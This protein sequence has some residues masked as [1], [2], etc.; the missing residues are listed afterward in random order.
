MT[1]REGIDH[2]EAGNEAALRAQFDLLARFAA[3]VR[4][5]GDED[6]IYAL[7][8]EV[9][10]E[11][12]GKRAIISVS[13]FDP[14]RAEYAPKALVGLSQIL[15]QLTAMVGTNPTQL[16]GDYSP[17][18]KQAMARGELLPLSG[19]V[20]E[21]AGELI[22]PA[23][24][25]AAARLLSIESVLVLGYARGDACGGVVIITRRSCPPPPRAAIEA[26]TR[27]AAGAIE[28]HRA[29]RALRASVGN[30]RAI[31]DGLDEPIYVSDPVSYELVFV[32]HALT[33]A[34]G[35][36]QQHRCYT[37]LHGRSS[38]CPFCNNARL[39]ASKSDASLIWEHRN[40]R[41]GRW[42]KCIDRLIDWSDGRR[43]RCE[44]AVDITD[45]KRAESELRAHRDL[46]NATLRLSKAGG[47]EWDVLHSRM[48]WTEESYRIHEVSP[49]ECPQ[50][51][52]E[53]FEAGLRSFRR[54]DRALLEAS[55]ERCIHQ[56]KSYSLELPLRTRSGRELWVQ[57]IGHPVFDGRRVV[58]VLGNY[59]DITERR[60]TEELLRRSEEDFRELVSQ[61]PFSI[62]VLD[63][64]GFTVQVNPAFEQLWGISMDRLKGHSL[65][66]DQAF[67]ARGLRSTLGEA[68][69][70][71]AG[72]F[73]RDQFVPFDPAFGAR[74]RIVD[75]IAYPIQRANG[76][77]RGVAIVH[78]DVTE[79]VQAEADRARIQVELAQAQKMETVGRLAGGI[80]HDFN[81]MLATILGYCDFALEQAKEQPTL[82]EDLQEIKNAAR[83]S[84]ELT[85]QLLTFARR[86]TVTP[87]RLELNRRI[88]ESL[89][90]LRRLLPESIELSWQPGDGVHDVMLD[91][92]QVEQLLTNLCVNAR[93]A[94]S[95]SGVICISTAQL[96]G[97]DQVKLSVSDNG[98]GMDA[99]T[100]SKLFEPFFTTKELGRGTGL[101]LSIV[102]GIVTQ[103]HGRVEVHSRVG[104]GSRFD[105]HLPTLPEGAA[106]SVEPVANEDGWRGEGLVLL[107]E[108]ELSL[109]KVSCRNLEALG[110]EVLSTPDPQEALTLAQRSERPIDVLLTDVIM[111]GLNGRELANSLQASYPQLRCVF[112]SGYTDDVIAPQGVLSEGEHFLAKP[113]T[114]E[115]L[116]AALRRVLAT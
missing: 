101:G 113:F 71:K 40:E 26:V 104:E 115:A 89:K 49:S 32:N 36:L 70:G 10:R 20:V 18:V 62:Q 91:P 88:E 99:E 65:L 43:L 8:T 94:I 66:F 56:G 6:S 50:G 47:W 9:L 79:Q 106:V 41:T 98:A 15:E 105:I 111:P 67:V 102:E 48:T 82:T 109:L 78:R 34:L 39:L 22:P 27:L 13:A 51:S 11:L 31:F 55:F 38:P 24:C 44:I 100:V 53:L 112:M 23:V 108:D 90:L 107:V 80:A 110:F 54:E 4:E 63:R 75:A 28:R 60:Q 30:L 12:I 21:L 73:P 64:G 57:T 74:S 1:R 59:V 84:S 25:R 93:D 61:A 14:Q 97:E 85:R 16:A 69:A 42:Y 86:Q 72:A 96:P 45:R 33:A 17:C 103:N 114:R 76:E 87:V 92:A 95:G 81:N 2:Q 5:V 19:G 68:F 77:L 3:E 29:E 35:P 37:Y 116:A 58:K 52:V 46:L 7:L 83:H